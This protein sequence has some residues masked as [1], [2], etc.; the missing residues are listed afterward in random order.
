MR[1]AFLAWLSLKQAG[2]SSEIDD[3]TEEWRARLW[4][5]DLCLYDGGHVKLAQAKAVKEPRSLWQVSKVDVFNCNCEITFFDSRG[6]KL[7]GL[8]K[9]ARR[10]SQVAWKKMSFML[11][12]WH[13]S[14]FTLK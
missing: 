9:R 13:E 1:T 8:W 14:F 3:L 6:S 11:A 2:D 12:A 7:R 5:G 10:A 4:P